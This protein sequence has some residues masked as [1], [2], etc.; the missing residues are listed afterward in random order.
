MSKFC[1]RVSKIEVIAL[2]S[3]V[4]RSRFENGRLLITI[5]GNVDGLLP[6]VE[7]KNFS[8]AGPQ[9]ILFY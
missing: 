3:V 2:M 6:A 1:L 9:Q 8:G 5:A 4:S 7:I